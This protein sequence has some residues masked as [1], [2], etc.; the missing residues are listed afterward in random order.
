[1]F[2]SSRCNRAAYSLV[3]EML[4]RIA[5]LS[6]ILITVW[7]TLILGML[8]ILRLIVSFSLPW[9]GTWARV[10][11]EIIKPT[12]SIGLTL[13]WLYFWNNLAI[14]YFRRSMRMRKQ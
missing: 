5:W 7:V 14:G 8:M 10:L 1:M 13:L 4:N 9:E 2:N 3:K 11:T 6:A 12:V